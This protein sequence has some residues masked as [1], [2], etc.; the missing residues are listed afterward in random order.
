[1]FP[2]TTL[3]NTDNCSLVKKYVYIYNELDLFY[4]F[5]FLLGVIV[6]VTIILLMQNNS[7]S[8]VDYNNNENN[9]RRYSNTELTTRLIIQL[10]HNIDNPGCT[11]TYNRFPENHPGHLRL[12]L[13]SKLVYILR[14]SMLSDQYK[15]GCTIGTIYKRGTYSYPEVSPEMAG[16]VLSAEERSG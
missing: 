6:I 11:L 3:T 13:R 9:T 14:T 4:L 16:V 10:R 1:M 12:E 5:C 15:F 7:I 2:V 8:E